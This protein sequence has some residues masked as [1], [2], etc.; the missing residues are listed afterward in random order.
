MDSESKN[1]LMKKDMY[2]NALSTRVEALEAASS[3]YASAG[4]SNMRLDKIL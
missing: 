4:I 3:S 1:S 2:F